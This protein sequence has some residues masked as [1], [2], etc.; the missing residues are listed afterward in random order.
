M[1][2][3]QTA[4]LSGAIW[5]KGRSVPRYYINGVLIASEGQ[6]EC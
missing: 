5:M 1:A 3:K 4:E 6:K 2:V